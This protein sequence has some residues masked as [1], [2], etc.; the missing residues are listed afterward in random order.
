MENVLRWNVTNWVTV[1]LMA[2][3]GMM[4]FGL[5][6]GSYRASMSGGEA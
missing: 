2:T 4:L 3:V 5:A 1:F 6:A